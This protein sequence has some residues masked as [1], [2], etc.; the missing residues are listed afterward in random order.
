VPADAPP[1]HVPDRDELL[2]LPGVRDRGDQGVAGAEPRAARGITIRVRWC[3]SRR[4]VPSAARFSPRAGLMRWC[5]RGGAGSSVITGSAGGDGRC[6]WAIGHRTAEAA[7]IA[8][9]LSSRHGRF[10]FATTPLQVVF[11]E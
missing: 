6:R 11:V 5:V 8:A 2:M 1:V 10:C 7:P 4:C 3:M 9:A